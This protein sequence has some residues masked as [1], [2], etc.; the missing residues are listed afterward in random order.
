MNTELYIAKRLIF[1]Q[2]KNA[3]L[4]RP[5]MRI[6]TASVALSIAVMLIAVAVL[7]GFK[8]QITQKVTG[9]LAHLQIVNYDGNTS[10][11]TAPIHYEQALFDSIGKISQVA[12][13]QAF[14]LK[15]G[16]IATQSDMQGVVL[17]GIDEHFDWSFFASCIVEGSVL[18]LQQNKSSNGVLISVHLANLLRLNLGD[19]LTTYFVQE[20]P[21]VRR[22]TIVGMYDT[23]FTDFDKLYVL[24]DIKHIQRLNAWSKQ[25]ITG[26]EIYLHNFAQLEQVTKQVEGIT[27]YHLRSQG[28]RLLVENVKQRFTQIFDWLALQD[29]NA[30]I[31]LWLMLLVAGFNMVSSLLIILLEHSTTIGVL[32]TLGMQNRS[33]QKIFIYQSAFIAGQGIFWGNVLGIGACVLQQLFGIVSLDPNTY[34][35][36]EVPILLNPLYILLLNVG[37]LCAIVAMLVLP[38]LLIARINPS[39]TLRFS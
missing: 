23:K 38:S 29:L 28:F 39:K 25:Q 36:S 32:K 14:A 33:I 10:Y 13:L 35:L 37:A 27:G 17:K 22:F 7:G 34:Y 3:R 12:H 26:I 21:R 20:P 8:Q 6:A 24:C 30:W 16:I 31:I 15:P 1:G 11:E 2:A 4:L 19:T 18:Q 5:I 9:F